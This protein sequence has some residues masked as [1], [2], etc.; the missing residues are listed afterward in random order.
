MD[1]IS[2]DS[3]AYVYEQLAAILERKIRTGEYPPGSRLPGELVMTHDYGVGP[4]TVRRA[5]TIL[6]DAGLVVTRP[7]R[8]TFV[9][10]PL[11]ASDDA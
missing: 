10:D 2:P 11:P 5:L 6:R 7:A 1:K 9:V 3:P 8:G 4:G